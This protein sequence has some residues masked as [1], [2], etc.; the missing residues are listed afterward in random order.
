MTEQTASAMK[1]SRC[2]T[3]I[4]SCAFCEQPNCPAPTCYR[5]LGVAFLDRLRPR[6]T[7]AASPRER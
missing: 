7:T 1:C 5:C 3:A 2:G 6:P 4:G